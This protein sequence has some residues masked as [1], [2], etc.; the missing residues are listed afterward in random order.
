MGSCI[1]ASAESIEAAVKACASRKKAGTAAYSGTHALIEQQQAKVKKEPQSPT[2][3]AGT[4]TISESPNPTATV[5]PQRTAPV[6]V[7]PP[8]QPKDPVTS[9]SSEK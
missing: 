3:T 8:N 9:A 4:S 1:S 7:I 2:Q 5:T 6:S